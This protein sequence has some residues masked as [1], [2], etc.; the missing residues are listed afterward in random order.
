MRF[1]TPKIWVLVLFSLLSFKDSFD[2]YT[3]RVPNTDQSLDMIA[4][5]GGKVNMGNTGKEVEVSDFWMAKYET[6]WDLYTVYMHKEM[7]IEAGVDAIARPTPPYVEMSFGQGKKDGFPVCNVTQFAAR[8]FCQ[9]LTEKTGDFYRL[10]T[11]AEWEYAAKAGTS[12]RFYFGE[13]ELQL[14]EH[15]WFFENS[16]GAYKKVGLLKPNS[17]GLHDMYG[18]VAEWTSDAYL[19]KYYDTT[20]DPYNAPEQVYPH[21]IKGGHWD[22]DA[23]DCSSISR[24]PSTAKLKIRDPQIPK[25]DWWLTNAPFLGFRVVRPKEKPSPE[26]I[27]S[28]FSKPPK[29]I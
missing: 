24:I 5:L 26:F 3:L 13:D 1:I 17:W 22:S 9:W 15:A 12:S 10:P 14:G 27:Q 2:N 29:D 20:K 18:N 28:Y 8:A 21:T 16:D 7:E 19:E 6:T 4:V 11:E 23:V 25:S